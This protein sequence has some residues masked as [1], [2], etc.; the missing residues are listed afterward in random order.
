[1]NIKDLIEKLHEMEVE[2]GTDIKVTIQ[3]GRDQ[4]P[5][6]YVSH[7][8]GYRRDRGVQHYVILEGGF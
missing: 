4:V 1:M 5:V 2:F 7:D 8:I 6:E 3:D